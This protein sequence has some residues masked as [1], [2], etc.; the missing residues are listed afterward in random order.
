M[1]RVL[2]RFKIQAKVVM[3]ILPLL[4]ALAA[5]G[6][7]GLYTTK[8][9]EARMT[10]SN[11]VVQLLSGFKRVYAAITLFLREPDLEKFTEAAS[12]TTAQISEID[13]TIHKI[14]GGQDVQ[15]LQK[16]RDDTQAILTNVNEIW[17]MRQGR[18]ELT[19]NISAQLDQLNSMQ[20]ELGKHAFKIV[21]QASQVD[22][23]RKQRL[24]ETLTLQGLVN[25]GEDLVKQLGSAKGW[26]APRNGEARRASLEALAE[27]LTKSGRSLSSFGIQDG[28]DLGK[29][30]SQFLKL[31]S[32]AQAYDPILEV[33]I[34][35]DLVRFLE[36]ART[37][38]TV[39]ISEAGAELAGRNVGSVAVDA[40]KVTKKLRS[41][42][43]NNSDVKT[44]FA[45][46]VG[47][48]TDDNVKAVERALFVY[49]GEVTLLAELGQIDPYFIEVPNVIKTINE[50]L[51][52]SAVGLKVNREAAEHQYKLAIDKINEVWA[53]VE[54]FAEGQRQLASS[55]RSLANSVSLSSMGFGFLTAILCGTALVLTLK[56]P[57][58]SI[59][60]TM[61]RLA[62]GS[63]DVPIAG[64]RRQDEIGEMARAL[65]VFKENAAQKIAIQAHAEN[66]HRRTEAEREANDRERAVTQQN[67]QQAVSLLA[68]GLK[69]LAGKDLRKTIDVSF[70]GDLDTL[71]RDFNSTIG[72]LSTT[73][74][75]IR[76]TSAEI[77]TNGR[78]LA[79][80]SQ[81][82]SRRN[83]QQASSIEQ[84]AAAIEEITLTVSEASKR[85][86][87]AAHTAERVRLEADSS[88][89]I[90]GNAIGAMSRIKEASD[91]ISTIVTVIDGIAFQT[92]LLA[93]N[94]GVEAAR[95]GEA[96][97]G[98]AVV[99]Q[100]V[101]E[102]A[103]R[104]ASAA[105][106]I[107]ALID[108][109]TSEVDSGVGF[110]EQTGHAL[111]NIVTKIRDVSQDVGQLS[112]S[113]QSQAKG[114]GEINEAVSTIEKVTQ[115]N[116][117]MAE[118]AGAATRKLAEQVDDLVALVG[119]F[120]LNETPCTIREVTAAELRRNSWNEGDNQERNVL[121]T[122]AA[123]SR[124]ITLIA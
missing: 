13:R 18:S 43:S 62:N 2:S 103:Q 76:A 28:A 31:T 33:A 108:H 85:A 1:D 12:L 94:A 3:L 44:A 35:T 69:N 124:G 117:A 19:E 48:P 107:T 92:N 23:T 26:S 84:T 112:L 80:A 110:V 74:S 120:A 60:D 41:I 122:S 42:V 4:L 36:K 96:G 29:Q 81:E 83:E 64:D 39:A 97:K 49:M 90:V 47:D 40:D 51:L 123:S 24:S 8:V 95:A 116:A 71:R 105:R 54:A 58:S 37:V 93:L 101:R 38:T 67:I 65:V 50:D 99:A 63:L 113:S 56:R 57:L 52:K 21:A 45:G 5:V 14:S 27:T 100:E 53:R 59:T 78:L 121:T 119:S 20:L 102:L 89:A 88:L 6:S 106:E 91:R 109:S 70:A 16:A 15:E 104:A 73:M 68:S 86:A 115:L 61:R 55:E 79:E 30:I 34:V 118:E 114:L 9:L 98:F 77:H 75:D 7:V 72:G 10:V 66:L 11:D 22:K 87:S 111:D 32:T 46:L 25:G 82:L 17:N